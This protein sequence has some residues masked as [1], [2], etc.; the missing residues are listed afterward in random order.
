MKV[1][2][3]AGFGLLV[4]AASLFAGGC[5]TARMAVP[6]F[7]EERADIYP[8]EGRQGFKI[9]EDF[10][11]GPYQVRDVRRGWTQRVAWDL[12]FAEGSVRRQDFEFTVH[13]P[14]GNRWRGNAVTGVRK[15]DISGRVGGGEWTW[16][17]AS[18]VNFL[19]RMEDERQAQFW[20]LAMAE[21]RGD[22]LMKGELSD[23]QII[24]RVEGSNRL[25]GTSM[26]LADA[27]GFIFYLGPRAVA[28]VEVIN[29]GV[30][31]FDREL[32]PVQ[33]DALAGAST[34]LLLYRDISG[35]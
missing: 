9:G 11:F 23:G 24:Y 4:I 2:Q 15:H 27:A 6:G 1:F 12:A 26:P 25:Q 8:C 14:D 28:A 19:V 10:S 20:T 7:L 32:E 33:R 18:E 17:L 22:I 16:D 35:R 30:V 21:G 31:F 5:Q 13:A 29:Q 34:A 3:S